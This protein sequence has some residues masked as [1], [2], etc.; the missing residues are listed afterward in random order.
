MTILTAAVEKL[1][2]QAQNFMKRTPELQTGTCFSWR[3]LLLTPLASAAVPGLMRGVA[4]AAGASS[5]RTALALRLG[6][7]CSGTAAMSAGG[8]AAESAF[9]ASIRIE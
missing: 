6:A 8:Q 7:A 4:S 1:K 9:T 5:K 3:P 2:G